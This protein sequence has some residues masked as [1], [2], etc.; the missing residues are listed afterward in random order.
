MVAVELRGVS[1]KYRRHT[2]RPLATTLKSYFLQD[3]WHR[4]DSPQNVLWALRDVNLKV[5]R[6]ATVGVIGRNGSGKS[7][8]L[9]VVSRILKPDA[10]TISVTGKVAALIELGAGFHPELTGRENVMINGIILGLTKREIR[11]KLDEIVE[12]AELRE[13]IDDPVRTY[14]SGMYM[15]LGFS[16]AVHADPDILLI[17]EI[18]SVGDEA[19]QGKCAEK[20]EE[21]Q[22]KGETLVLVSHDLAAVARWCDE[23]AWLDRGIIRDQGDPQKVIE[24]YR[25]AIAGK[26][27][28][29][30]TTPAA[31]VHVEMTTSPRPC[32]SD[33]VEIVAVQLLDGTG[34][35]QSVYRTG[36]PMIVEIRYLAHRPVLDVVFGVAILRN[37]GFRCF[38][39]NTQLEGIE[40][41]PLGKRGT[42][43]V[44]LDN[45]PIAEGSYFLDVAVH[46]KSGKLYDS[47]NLLHPFTISSKVKSV[48]MLRIPH[49]WIFRPETNEEPAGEGAGS[50]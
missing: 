42:A 50:T 27:P 1:K 46:S 18:L 26:A 13:Y 47:H 5:E 20:I 19:F 36:D 3:L 49:R 29:S 11:A 48:G 44:L 4:R 30:E 9:K 28:R 25:Q 31:E 34:R 8:L 37:D 38:G 45:L 41:S 40:P 43:E 10:G 17:D 33:E 32:A 16:V 23:A 7:T 24:A 39:T 2:E 22:R 35:P 6:G 21:L 12:F 15:R 14:S